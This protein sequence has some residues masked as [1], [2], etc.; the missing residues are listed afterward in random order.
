MS[1]LLLYST[2][3]SARRRFTNLRHQS[4][5]V[6]YEGLKMFWQRG[7]DYRSKFLALLLHFRLQKVRMERENFVWAG[8]VSTD[9]LGLRYLVPLCG[10]CYEVSV[11]PKFHFKSF[12][13]IIYVTKILTEIYLSTQ[14]LID[15]S[16][17][18]KILYKYINYVQV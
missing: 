15:I 17:S 13:T 5:S 6:L 3:H 12:S 8:H 11:H 2:F 9:T 7:R 4:C 14:G 16:S 1:L 10:N 18:F